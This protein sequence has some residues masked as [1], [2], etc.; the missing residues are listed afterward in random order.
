ML[1]E[2]TNQG[3]QL[4]P[5]SASGETCIFMVHREIPESPALPNSPSDGA[6]EI[7]PRK[8]LC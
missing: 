1:C 5:E 6:L 4:C 2:D 7:P 8:T 3:G